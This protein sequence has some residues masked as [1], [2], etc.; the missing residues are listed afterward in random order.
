MNDETHGKQ[1]AGGVSI[2]AACWTRQPSKVSKAET[3]YST[4]SINEQSAC[5]SNSEVGQTSMLKHD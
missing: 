2:G 3:L 1:S 4:G 5:P